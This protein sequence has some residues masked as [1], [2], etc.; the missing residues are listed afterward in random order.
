MPSALQGSLGA[1]VT[2]FGDMDFVYIQTGITLSLETDYSEAL[3]RSGGLIA[4]PQGVSR[5]RLSIEGIVVREIDGSI[6][7]S[8]LAS[9]SVIELMQEVHRRVKAGSNKK[10]RKRIKNG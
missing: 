10:E 6:A 1:G 4:V 3:D 8:A 2:S 5:Q 9:F 7:Q